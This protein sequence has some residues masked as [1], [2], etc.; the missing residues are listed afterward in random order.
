MKSVNLLKGQHILLCTFAVFVPAGAALLLQH[1]VNLPGL[2]GCCCQQAL[3]A[4]LCACGAAG[5]LWHQ[6]DVCA[7]SRLLCTG[8]GCVEVGTS[9]ERL[10]CMAVELLV[11]PLGC[12]TPACMCVLMCVAGCRQ[13][14]LD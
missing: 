12:V 4:P 11:A 8:R 10:C 3:E 1:A 13:W 5:A 14:G 2:S 9:A 7:V 6:Q